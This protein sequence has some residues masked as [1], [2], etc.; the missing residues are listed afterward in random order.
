MLEVF[1]ALVGLSI[2]YV[3]CKSAQKDHKAFPLGLSVIRLQFISPVNTISL[4]RDKA[5]T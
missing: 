4:L 2:S 1:F 5:F 3:E